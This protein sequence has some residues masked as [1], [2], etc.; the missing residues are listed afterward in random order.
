[1]T[2]LDAV[3]DDLRGLMRAETPLRK[4]WEFAA[5]AVSPRFA[6]WK[7]RQRGERLTQSDYLRDPRFREM[8]REYV[9]RVK[10]GEVSRR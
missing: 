3:F 10:A 5:A 8:V 4:D 9:R 1:M 7:M 6:E 2:D